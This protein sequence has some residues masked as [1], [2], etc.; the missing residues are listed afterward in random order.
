MVKLSDLGLTGTENPQITGVSIDSRDVKEGH[1]FA[2]LP[3]SRMHGGEFIQYA[4]RQGACAILTVHAG[5]RVAADVI[6][7][8]QPSMVVV[9]DPRQALAYA[10]ALWFGAQPNVAVAVTGTNGK[11]S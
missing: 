6:Q 8:F 3:G 4:L 7:Q 11:T 2:A 10:A 5:A 9:E 1:L